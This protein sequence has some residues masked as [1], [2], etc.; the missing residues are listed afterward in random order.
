MGVRGLLRQFFKKRV[1]V[2]GHRSTKHHHQNYTGAIIREMDDMLTVNTLHIDANFLL[3][4]IVAYAYALGDHNTPRNRSRLERMTPENRNIRC[5]R[6]IE[7]AITHIITEIVKPTNLVTINIDGVVPMAKI[8]QQRQRRY[9]GS[10]DAQS[11]SFFD[12]VAITPGTTWMTAFDTYFKEAMKRIHKTS[13]ANNLAAELIYSSHLVPGEG[14]HK[15]LDYL[16]DHSFE[17]NQMKGSHVIIGGDSDLVLLAMISGINNLY[18]ITDVTIPIIESV[19][20]N[21]IVVD[22]RANPMFEPDVIIIDKLKEGIKFELN[23][24]VSAVNDFVFALTLVGNDF[25]PRHPSMNDLQGGIDA[26]MDVMRISVPSLIDVGTKAVNWVNFLKLLKELHSGN[27]NN[28]IPDEMSRIIKYNKEI[29]SFRAPSRPY[30]A[31]SKYMID[32]NLESKELYRVFRSCWYNNAMSQFVNV[33]ISPNDILNMC[34]DYL[35]GISWVNKYYVVGTNYVSKSWSYGNGYSPMFIDVINVL[36]AILEV[37]TELETLNVREIPGEPQLTPLHQLLAVM[38]PTAG[39]YIPME[40]RSLWDDESI[41]AELFVVSMIVDQDGFIPHPRNLSYQGLYKDSKVE[42]SWQGVVDVGPAP[43]QLLIDSINELKLKDD[44]L[45]RYKPQNYMKIYTT[46]TAT[47]KSTTDVGTQVIHDKYTGN[48]KQYNTSRGG[49][50]GGRGG[51]K[52]YQHYLP[53]GK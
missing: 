36:D 6:M 9:A 18:V 14:E 33:P 26:I 29:D 42:P 13:V 46:N 21:S 17:I 12:T 16:R 5:F 52:H 23:N 10:L 7:Y 39:V 4:A 37:D 48:R 19:N 3:Y 49:G 41:A 1:S 40:I 28:A 2:S 27:H 32:N 20:N 24:R 15:L 8:W 34:M 43:F 30:Q 44:I 25:I 45:N 50:R 53:N 11:G 22:I 47:T 51:K 38:P 31:A 35:Y